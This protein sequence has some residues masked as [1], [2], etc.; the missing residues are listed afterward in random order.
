MKGS[1]VLVVA[2]A[3][4]ATASGERCVMNDK[5]RGI[6]TMLAQGA[7]DARTLQS[8][9]GPE[10]ACDCEDNEMKAY[11]SV[12]HSKA[13]LCCIPKGLSCRTKPSE[14]DGLPEEKRL[15]KNQWKMCAEDESFCNGEQLILPSPDTAKFP[16]GKDPVCGVE[17]TEA[18][19]VAKKLGIPLRACAGSFFDRCECEEG[20]T[21]IMRPY[22]EFNGKKFLQPD[23][24]AAGASEDSD[25][26]KE[27][28]TTEGDLDQAADDEAKKE[29]EE[30]EQSTPSLRSNKS[31]KKT[32]DA[33]FA[34]QNKLETDDKKSTESEFFGDAKK[35]E[36]SFFK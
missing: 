14:T 16:D 13:H 26:A 4:L 20:E 25:D 9:L 24:E 18:F 23:C 29:D 27:P 10:W 33:F 15:S 11:C 31:K 19:D 5:T 35:Q 6:A 1:A 36:D 34:D 32:E 12:G 30:D 17:G 28:K 8:K 3:V 7:S 2:A 21:K 22:M